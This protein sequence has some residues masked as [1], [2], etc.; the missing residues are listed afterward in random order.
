MQSPEITSLWN[1]GAQGCLQLGSP[2]VVHILIPCQESRQGICLLLQPLVPSP[3]QQT[4]S[5]RQQ[6]KE[7]RGLP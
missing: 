7:D 4:K 3:E 2:K 5:E 1:G 6:R